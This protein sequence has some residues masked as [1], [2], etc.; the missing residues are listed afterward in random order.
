VLKRYTWL[1]L[2]FAIGLVVFTRPSVAED[3]PR[4][5]GKDKEKDKE[6][7]KPDS[8]VPKNETVKVEKGPLTAAVVLKGTIQSEAATELSI[9]LKSWTG[10]LVARKSIEHGTAVKPGDVLVEFETEKL[11]REI[12]DARQE[13][14]LAQLAIRQAELELPILEKQAPLDLAAAERDYKE[15][16]DDL[17]RFT[18]VDRKMMVQSADFM[19]KSSNFYLD[20]AKEE[21]KQLQKMYRD[22]DL[23]E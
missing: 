11:D 16:V 6:K 19:L 23:T 9:K 14:E 13:R 3:P 22:K 17:K 21:L 18:E 7:A 15:A 8:D 1:I 4:P 10:Q 5:Q 20:Y 2:L 12:R